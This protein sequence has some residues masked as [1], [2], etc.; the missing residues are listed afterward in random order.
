ML[1]W[2]KKRS[3]KEALLIDGARRVGKSWIVE[4]FAKNEYDSYLLIDFSNTPN[5]IRR[6]FVDY[7]T[8]PIAGTCVHNH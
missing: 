5:A 3:N 2:K 1:L 6:L 7:D 4:E 8:F